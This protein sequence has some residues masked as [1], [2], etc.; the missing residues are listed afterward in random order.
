LA[1]DGGGGEDEEEEEERDE[2]DEPLTEKDVY[3]KNLVLRSCDR[4]AFMRAWEEECNLQLPHRA[5]REEKPV[6][7]ATQ[8]I[9]NVGRKI[10]AANESLAKRAHGVVSEMAAS[11][12]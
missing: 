6:H 12:V 7:N 4:D 3:E 5:D 2:G 9:T 10:W 1:V 11:A 8:E